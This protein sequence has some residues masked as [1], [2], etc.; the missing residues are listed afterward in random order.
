MPSTADVGRREG[1]VEVPSREWVIMGEWAV[2]YLSCRVG[3]SW[4]IGSHMWDRW[5]FTMF[6]LREGS[7]TLINMTSLM[8]LVLPCNSL[9]IMEKQSALIGCPVMLL[10]WWMGEGALRCSLTLSPNVLPDSPIYC[11]GQFMWGYVNLYI[12][13]LSVVYGPIKDHYIPHT[14]LPPSHPYLHTSICSPCVM[15]TL[16][17]SLDPICH[18]DLG[19]ASVH[20]YICQTFLYLSVHPLP[21][22]S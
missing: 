16:G 8:F 15:R 11:S 3:V 17:E 10:C 9:C 4:S 20:Q 7:L 19:G 21:L 6:L 12:M 13:P 18:G 2:Y 14:P 22:S 5:Y 1:G